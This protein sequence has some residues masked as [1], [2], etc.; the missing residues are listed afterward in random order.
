MVTE[1]EYLI[2]SGLSYGFFENEDIGHSLEEVLFLNKESKE[3]LLNFP[4]EIWSYSGRDIFEKSFSPFLNKW[5][6]LGIKDETYSKGK[7]KTGF[8]AVA[9]EKDKKVIIAYRG[10]EIGSFGEAY[11]DF[12]E[13]DL[14]I[15]LDK[16]PRQLE[17]GVEFYRELLEAGYKSISLTGHSLGG[18]IAQYVALISDMEGYG[19]PKVYT[20]NAVGINKNGILSIED[21]VRFDHIVNKKYRVLK[22]NEVGYK[23]VRAYYYNYLIRALK[24]MNYITDKESIS[25]ISREDF[26]LEI[27]PEFLKKIEEVLI[28]SSKTRLTFFD[29]KEKTGNKDIIVNPLS[30]LDDC[31]DEDIIY[32]SLMAGRRFMKKF[33][34]N[35]RYDDYIVNFVHTEDF[36][37]SLYNHLGSAY[38]VNKGL[39]QLDDNLHPL[40]KKVY[41]FRKAMRTYHMYQVFLPFFSLEGLKKGTIR[42]EL[43]EDYIAAEIRKIIYQ[44]K[45]L[46]DGFLGFYYSGEKLTPRNY[47]KVKKDLLIGMEKSKSDIKYLKEAT[48][49]IKR[50]NFDSF[51]RVWGKV[52]RKLGSPFIKQ[53]IFDLIIFDD[54]NK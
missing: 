10:S 13:T 1:L 23:K 50:M 43:N 28:A 11:K 26:K 3:R 16:K 53:D 39:I 25:D 54:R 20:W 32:N 36:T 47:Y 40:L 21:F 38:A 52:L 7:D 5:K 33:K 9:F 46:D 42:K 45:N 44:E 31:F 22:E 37:I 2:L 48:I 15:G 19:I 6:V 34:I 29:R 30:F 49:L 12:I 14:L 8:Y 41:A 35:H 27:E 24:R 4:N 18:G 17:Q 51:N